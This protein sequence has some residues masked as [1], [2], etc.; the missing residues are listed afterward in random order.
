[1][2]YHWLPPI[3]GGSEVWL[4]LE[5]T[6]TALNEAGLLFATLEQILISTT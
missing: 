1:M 2:E 6:C 3:K 4:S 5:L